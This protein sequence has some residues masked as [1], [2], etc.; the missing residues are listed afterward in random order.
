MV[1]KDDA[2]ILAKNKIE[3]KRKHYS[4]DKNVKIVHKTE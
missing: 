2:E 3:K 1:L 4:N